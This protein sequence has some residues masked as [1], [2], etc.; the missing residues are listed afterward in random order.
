MKDWN[1]SEISQICDSIDDTNDTFLNAADVEMQTCDET[2]DSPFCD[3]TPDSPSFTRVESPEKPADTPNN[4]DR[5]RPRK[6]T[7]RRN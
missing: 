4:T 1:C 3:E 6:F 2:P 7:V 5:P